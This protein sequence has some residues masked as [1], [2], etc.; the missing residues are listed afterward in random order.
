VAPPS[1]SDRV[2]LDRAEPSDDFEDGV[3]TSFHR[4]SRREE[5][6]GDEEPAGCFRCDLHGVDASAQVKRPADLFVPPGPDEPYNPA[7]GWVRAVPG[8]REG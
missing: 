3:A 1:D 4:P 7:L 6:P 2:E 8:L 5:M